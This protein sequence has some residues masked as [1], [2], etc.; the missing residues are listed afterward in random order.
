MDG[1]RAAPL[2]GWAIIVGLWLTLVYL[3]TFYA[4]LP[5]IGPDRLY[6][7]LGTRLYNSVVPMG[8][9]VLLL[10]LF[11][12]LLAW[13]IPF[14]ITGGVAA[15]VLK[16]ALGRYPR[17]RRIRIAAAVALLCTAALPL[18]LFDGWPDPLAAIVFGDDTEFA[19]GYT[20]LGFLRIRQGMSSDEVVRC[21][22]EPLRR[23]PDNAGGERWFWTRSPHDS[24]YRIR[25]VLFRDGRVVT[26]ESEFYVD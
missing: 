6:G 16:A 12:L 11:Y 7:M 14:A 2:I 17:R 5:A 23:Y 20:T 24:S 1:R 19:P 25:A 22:G 10:S 18:V 26:R 3:L 9:F 13:G 8:G 15:A 21:I 4:V